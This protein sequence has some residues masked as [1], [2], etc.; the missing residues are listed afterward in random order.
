MT[1]EGVEEKTS[2]G[3]PARKSGNEDEI[4]K[5]GQ[6]QSVKCFTTRGDMNEVD[7]QCR[8]REGPIKCRVMSHEWSITDNN[9]QCYDSSSAAV[10]EEA[11][12]KG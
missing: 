1:G 9:R 12:G 4:I 7:V 6:G 8:A 5:R 3:Q 2:S 11:R 10:T